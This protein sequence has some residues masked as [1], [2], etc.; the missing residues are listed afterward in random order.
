MFVIQMNLV[1]DLSD[2]FG[3]N[4]EGKIYTGQELVKLNNTIDQLLLIY[5]KLSAERLWAIVNQVPDEIWGTIV[6]MHKDTFDGWQTLRFVSKKWYYTIPK[7]ASKISFIDARSPLN[8][9]S[10]SSYENMRFIKTKNTFKINFC[11]TAFRNLK[12]LYIQYHRGKDWQHEYIDNLNLPL[13]THVTFSGEWVQCRGIISQ[14]TRL[15]L[16]GCT[17]NDFH[18]TKYTS[19]T[20]LKMKDV[21]RSGGGNVM[22]IPSHVIFVVTDKSIKMSPTQLNYTGTI[23]IMAN[24]YTYVGD[25]CNG[26]M[27]GKGAMQFKDGD[28]YTGEFLDDHKHGHGIRTYGR[29]AYGVYGRNVLSH[30]G[31]WYRGL[32]NGKIITTFLDGTK[33]EEN[34]SNGKKLI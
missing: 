6:G 15:S 13:L 4:S 2:F 23:K 28:A 26:K 19:L 8:P 17:V 31:T 16:K 18:F 22:C 32:L 12:K 33:S 14:I 21:Y 1:T 27:T 34:W 24:N 10:L 29:E 20:H 30:E 3:E 9:A 25:F 7:F 11:L 5:K